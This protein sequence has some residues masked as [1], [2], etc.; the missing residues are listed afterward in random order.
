MGRRACHIGRQES[1]G[2]VGKKELARQVRG[3]T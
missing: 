1:H 3:L 2:M